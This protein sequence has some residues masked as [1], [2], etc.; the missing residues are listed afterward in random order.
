M[1]QEEARREIVR[2]WR[3]LPPDQRR[4]EEQAAAFARA[5]QG[6]FEFRVTGDRYQ[7]VKH[8]LLEH[9]DGL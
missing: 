7:V 9:L 5:I 1:R 3:A 6:E 2:L 4:T 8:W